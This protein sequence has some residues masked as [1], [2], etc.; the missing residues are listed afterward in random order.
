MG[1][2][3]EPKSLREFHEKQKF[4]SVLG[5]GGREE[6]GVN[7]DESESDFWNQFFEKALSDAGRGRHR[8]ST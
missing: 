4:V 2:K 7:I 5:S 1:E 8:I 6:T 3:C